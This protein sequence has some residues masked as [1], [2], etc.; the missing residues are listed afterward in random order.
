MGK[1]CDETVTIIDDLIAKLNEN[2]HTIF[3]FVII[4]FSLIKPHPLTFSFRDGCSC[5]W[6]RG[7]L[8]FLARTIATQIEVSSDFD[9]VDFIDFFPTCS[10]SHQ[11]KKSS[12]ANLLQTTP[13]P[14]LGSN[15]FRQHMFPQHTH[16]GDRRLTTISHLASAARFTRQEI[17]HLIAA[18]HTGLRQWHTSNDPHRPVKSSGRDKSSQRTRLGDTRR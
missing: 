4:Y 9:S 2:L 16:A 5:R 6:S 14:G 1:N 3:H 15:E 10:S 18:S 7:R 11:K 13:R 12:C 17:A 8:V